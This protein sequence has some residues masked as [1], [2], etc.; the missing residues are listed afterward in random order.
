MFFAFPVLLSSFQVVSASCFHGTSLSPR[1]QAEVHVSNFSYSGVRGPLNWAGL[2]PAWSACR[3]GTH[4][5]PIVIDPSTMTRLHVGLSLLRVDITPVATCAPLVN[6]GSTLEVMLPDHQGQTSYA[7]KTYA[8]KQFHMH[9]PSEHHI[10]GEYYPLEMHMVH[11]A[12]DSSILVLAILFQISLD[13]PTRLF[14]SITRNLVDVSEPGSET[15]TGPLDFDALVNG[16]NDLGSGVPI[17][18]YNGSLTTP[19]CTE[20]VTWLVRGAPLSVDVL[21]YNRLKRV[22]KFNS[23]YTQNSPGAQNLLELGDDYKVRTS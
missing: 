22:L 23:R 7:G 16:F 14:S 13:W 10:S 5:S 19:P 15:T 18:I 6:L 12:P 1:S 20:G 3:K 4:Q 21:T 9:T 2:D 17:Y 8:L 11:Q